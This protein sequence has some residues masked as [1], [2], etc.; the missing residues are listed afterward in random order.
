M[1]SD[2]P[3]L[4]GSDARFE[5]VLTEI[6]QAEEQGQTP[7]LQA[8][9]ERFPDLKAPLREFFRNRACFARLAPQLAPTPA[10]AESGTPSTADTIAGANGT[11]PPPHPGV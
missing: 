7:D 1:P 3:E 4:S 9:L 5:Q 10:D 8:Y 6:L 11:G 2:T